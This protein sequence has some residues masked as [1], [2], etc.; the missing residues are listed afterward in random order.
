MRA[1]AAR[2][3]RV[4]GSGPSV[5]VWARRVHGGRR[6]HVVAAL[7]GLG[8]AL[9]ACNTEGDN[10]L[11]DDEGTPPAEATGQVADCVTGDW[12]A[13]G[14][15]GEIGGVAGEGTISGGAGVF[16]TVNPDGSARV[17][18]SGM[19]PL[20]F[21]GQLAEVDVSGEFTYAGTADGMV[22]TDVDT[23]SGQWSVDEP[24][25][26]SDVRVTL[27]TTEPVESRPLD[28]TSLG[29][30]IEQA[31]ELTGDVVDVDPVLSDGTF[32]CRDDTLV[33]DS[34]GGTGLTWTLERA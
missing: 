30:A 8:L 24:A 29:E 21:D 4:T 2:T 1:L 13:A 16:V 15:D 14:V 12:V 10:G 32:D 5:N 25:D 28:D 18:F 23:T 33:L 27:E 9:A 11:A 7:A 34:S 3:H 19:E 17:D 26:W 20:N 31:E 22:R 6:G